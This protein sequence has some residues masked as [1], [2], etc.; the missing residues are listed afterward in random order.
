M[1]VR[2]SADA[3]MPSPHVGPQLQPLQRLRTRAT[4]GPIGPVGLIILSATFYLY[5]NNSFSVLTDCVGKLTPPPPPRLKFC[6]LF[7]SWGRK[8]KRGSAGSAEP[9]FYGRI[10]SLI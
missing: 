4:I 9:L 1:R 6:F 8:S 7:S 10:F 2:I 3:A 5:K